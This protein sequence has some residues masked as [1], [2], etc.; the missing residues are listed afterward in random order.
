MKNT[1]RLHYGEPNGNWRSLA[2]I[3]DVALATRRI[4][5][6]STIAPTRWYSGPRALMTSRRFAGNVIELSRRSSGGADIVGVSPAP[7]MPRVSSPPMAQPP[8][9]YRRLRLRITG[10]SPLLMHSGALASPMNPIAR[11][12]KAVSSKRAKTDADFEELARLEFL[13]SLYLSGG[14]PC[15]PGEVFETCL[16]QAAKKARRGAPAKAGII[17]D[18]NFALD[19]DGPRTP[20]ELWAEERFRFVAGVRIGA[21]VMRTR[22]RFDRWEATIDVD[23]LPDQI[24]EREVLEFSVVAGRT[25]GIGDWRPRFGRFTVES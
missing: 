20:H 22:P 24:N 1:S 10:V 17:C 25:I 16:V 7:L 8:E 15:I 12:M 5:L 11:E 14:E 18:G 3:T 6:R 21:R 9:G 4:P 23:Y 13:G 19:Y 2:T